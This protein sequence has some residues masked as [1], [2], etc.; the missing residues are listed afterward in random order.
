MKLTLENDTLETMVVETATR[1]HSEAVAPDGRR[2]HLV[3]PPSNLP[4]ERWD[5]EDGETWWR[6]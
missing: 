2:F 6:K 3:G 4:G 5:E 1:D